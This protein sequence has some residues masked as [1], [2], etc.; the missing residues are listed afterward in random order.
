M[1]EVQ[2]DRDYIDDAFVAKLNS[3]DEGTINSL[4]KLMLEHYDIELTYEKIEYL[5]Q[6]VKTMYSSEANPEHFI[7]QLKYLINKGIYNRLLKKYKNDLAEIGIKAEIIELITDLQKKAYEENQ[8][9][10][11]AK[12]KNE[13]ATVKDFS[14]ETEMPVS[15]SDYPLEIEGKNN[16]DVKKQNVIFN[17]KLVED[18]KNS[19]HMFKIEKDKLIQFYEQIEIIQE[20]IDKLS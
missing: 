6:E 12:S 16:E 1:N 4:I 3:L 7:R 17:F 10:N 18:N 13:T 14:I 5:N 8:R 9:K 15:Y 20:K 11:E 19:D 2:I